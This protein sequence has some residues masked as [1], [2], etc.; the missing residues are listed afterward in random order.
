M[1]IRGK[2]YAPEGFRF[3]ERAL[4]YLKFEI[5]CELSQQEIKV[6]SDAICAFELEMQ[7]D[8]PPIYPPLIST[9][10]ITD[11]A[12]FTCCFDDEPAFYGQAMR[13]I[14]LPVDRWRKFQ[15]PLLYL[16]GFQTV[17]EELCHTH[18]LVD[19][20]ILVKRRVLACAKQL[21]P[22]LEFEDL[23]LMDAL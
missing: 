1:Y 22:K 11:G 8:P 17:L 23:Y 7:F 5:H 18:Y 4:E 20:E 3:P 13:L 21:Y 10:I 12:E 16:V 9:M 15:P 6:I 19:D 2:R 14:H